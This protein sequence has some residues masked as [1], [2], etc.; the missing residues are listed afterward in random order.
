MN[1]RLPELLDHLL[2]LP[3]KADLLGLFLLS[4]RC[5][6][7]HPSAPRGEQRSLVERVVRLVEL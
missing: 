5:R 6:W 3:L 1:L 2:P 4:L 7:R